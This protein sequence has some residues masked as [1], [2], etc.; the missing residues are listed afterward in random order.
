MLRHLLTESE[1]LVA[2]FAGARIEIL[3]KKG[4]VGLRAVAPFAGA[5]I[6]ML[7]GVP[8]SSAVVVAPFAGA[9]IEICMTVTQWELQSSL[10]SRERGL[11]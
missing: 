2:P 3:I 4:Y 6:E 5:R 10:P 1:E 8:I 7:N 9:R 11:K